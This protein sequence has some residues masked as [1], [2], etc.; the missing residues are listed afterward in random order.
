MHVR[1]PSILIL[2]LILSPGVASAPTAIQGQPSVSL[3]ECNP[4]AGLQL[5]VS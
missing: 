2:T 1:L 4:P 3:T 5:P